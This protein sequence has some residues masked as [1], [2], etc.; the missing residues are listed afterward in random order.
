M[1][2]IQ[3]PGLG[4]DYFSFQ[5]S[6]FPGLTPSLALNPFS[7]TYFP[8]LEASRVSAHETSLMEHSGLTPHHHNHLNSDPK[9]GLSGAFDMKSLLMSG[10]NHCQ[11]SSNPSSNMTCASPYNLMVPCGCPSLHPSTQAPSLGLQPF[12]SMAQ[13]SGSTL[14]LASTSES[15]ASCLIRPKLQSHQR[16]DDRNKANSGS[17]SPHGFRLNHPTPSNTSSASSSPSSPVPTHSINLFG[18]YS[19]YMSGKCCQ[20]QLNACQ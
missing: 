5:R 11:P 20:K 14:S 1:P 6:L 10:H 15:Q 17:P 16:L 19:Q 4:V 13:S 12:V 7:E 18:L 8:S 3:T 9:L 2:Y